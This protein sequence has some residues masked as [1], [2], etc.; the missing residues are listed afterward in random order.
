MIARLAVVT[1]LL[2]PLGAIAET[3]LRR[4]IG[5]LLIGGIGVVA[6]VPRRPDALSV[7]GGARL[8]RSTP[9]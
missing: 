7:A 9:C 1:M 2:G 5:F 8:R 4:A 3:N 6:R